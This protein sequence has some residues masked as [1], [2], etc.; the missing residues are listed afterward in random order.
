M[1][2]PELVLAN[3]R[4]RTISMATGRNDKKRAD[5]AELDRS[6]RDDT[7]ENQKAEDPAPDHL[8]A[9]EQKPQCSHVGGSKRGEAPAG[10]S[11][12]DQE[13]LDLC[14]S[15]ITGK[16]ELEKEEVE[17]MAPQVGQCDSDVDDDRYTM[18]EV[19]PA[20]VEGLLYDE[21]CN[22]HQTSERVGS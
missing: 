14:A 3:L 19:P 5:A 18:D 20:N 8:Q 12:A 21:Y 6:E 4:T 10:C 15:P 7:I 2:I 13:R 9:Q 22:L 16:G 1:S 17:L 11:E